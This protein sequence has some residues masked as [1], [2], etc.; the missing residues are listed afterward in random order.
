MSA[1]ASS[2][3][4]VIRPMHET[5][6]EA[7]MDIEE[8]AYAYPWTAGIF[9][10]CIRVGYCCFV[11]EVDDWVRAYAV[12]SVAAGEAHLLN[13]CVCPDW[14]GAGLG[15][16]LLDHV[17]AQAERL[18]AA[19]LFLEVRPSNAPALHLYRSMG[20]EQIGRRRGYYPAP[21]GREDAWVMARCPDAD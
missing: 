10:D 14:Q 19:Q 12:M 5:D 8:A 21:G 1:L 11:C 3:V 2:A 20:F 16:R 18:G 4:P 6:I 17:L 7:V 13:I 9:A 15:R